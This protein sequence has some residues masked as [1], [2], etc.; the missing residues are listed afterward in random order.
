MPE[1][2]SMIEGVSEVGMVP[3]SQQADQERSLVDTDPAKLLPFECRLIPDDPNVE[4]LERSYKGSMGY[5]E[6]PII[7]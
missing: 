1:A 6:A 3:Y 7:G 2:V 5:G 4:K